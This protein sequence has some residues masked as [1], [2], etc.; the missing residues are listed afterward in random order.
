MN[1]YNMMNESD[2]GASAAAEED[3]RT[4]ARGSDFIGGRTRDFCRTERCYSG[5]QSEM[6]A[7][8]TRLNERIVRQSG[9]ASFAAPTKARPRSFLFSLTC[10]VSS[11]PFLSFS[12]FKRTEREADKQSG[13]LQRRLSALKNALICLACHERL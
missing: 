7:T 6:H 1:E 11:S 12:L 5:E 2:R 13:A 10:L 3:V 9:R 8:T 4:N